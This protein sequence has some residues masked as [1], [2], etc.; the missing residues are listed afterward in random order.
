[1]KN[2]Y[3]FRHLFA[4]PS[5]IEGAARLLDLGVTMQ[6][7]NTSRTD[8]EADIKAMRNDWRTVGNDLKT[9][10]KSYEQTT[11]STK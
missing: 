3:S 7:Y 5:F 6:Q 9:S 1:M 11:P 8:T 10:M 2:S 4:R